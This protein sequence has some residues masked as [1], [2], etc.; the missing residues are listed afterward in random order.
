ME[1]GLGKEVKLRH[2]LGPRSVPCLNG[3]VRRVGRRKGPEEKSIEK[4]T[5]SGY[6]NLNRPF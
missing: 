6:T 2:P 5:D 1:G 4:V 3:D